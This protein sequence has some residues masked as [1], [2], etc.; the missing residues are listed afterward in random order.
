MLPYFIPLHE[1]SYFERSEM[2]AA[3][4]NRV[5]QLYY[6][7]KVIS[8]SPRLLWYHVKRMTRGMLGRARTADGNRT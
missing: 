4:G 2:L 5:L 1:H 8:L 3:S 7:G 6:Y